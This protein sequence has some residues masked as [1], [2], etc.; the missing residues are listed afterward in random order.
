MPALKRWHRGRVVL[1]GDAAHVASPSSGQGASMAFEDAVQLARCLRDRGD[2]T[3]AFHAYQRLRTT[4]STR[5][6]RER[7]KSTAA[8]PPRARAGSCAI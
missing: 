3:V 7:N 8:R 6:W 4:A 1:I 5:C 2:P